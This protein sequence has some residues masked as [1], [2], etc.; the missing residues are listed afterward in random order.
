VTPD[1][2]IE[3]LIPGAAL[4]TTDVRFGNAE[5][6]S[7]RAAL[8][9]P[10]PESRLVPEPLLVAACIRAF[11]ATFGRVP[12]TLHLGQDLSVRRTPEAGDL[13]RVGGVVAQAG[14]ARKGW[15]FQVEVEGHLADGTPCFDGRMTGQVLR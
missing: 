8:R 6:T 11:D 2:L 9:L 5:L 1:E 12:G 14:S 15:R 7:Y 4:T 13:I 3:Q 10:G